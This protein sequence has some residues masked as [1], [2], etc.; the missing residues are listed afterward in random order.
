MYQES[1]IRNNPARFVDTEWVNVD[2]LELE[3]DALS[4]FTI[5]WMART[6]SAVIG[7]LHFTPLI[8]TLPILDISLYICFTASGFTY[9]I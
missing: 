2:V 8:I 5:V 6:I 9:S 4:A 7:H 3:I 1:F